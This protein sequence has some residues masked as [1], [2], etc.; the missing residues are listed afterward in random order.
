MGDKLK[1]WRVGQRMTIKEAATRLGVCPRTWHRW[2][3]GE[4]FPPIVRWVGIERVTGRSV[5]ADDLFRAS[6]EKAA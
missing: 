6:R 4:R 5:T 2:E 3:I 1:A